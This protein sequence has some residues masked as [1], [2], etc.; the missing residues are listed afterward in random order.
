MPEN[1]RLRMLWNTNAMW[2]PSGYA[3]VIRDLAP[4]IR[5]EGY[6][7]GIINFYGQ[8][9]GMFGIEGIAQYP[10]I[11]DQWGADAMILHQK[12]FQ[13]D[14]VISLQ[15]IWVL[16]PEAVKQVKNWI[17]YLPID[18]DPIPP[19][20]FE[21][22]KL[23]YR[24]IAMSKF[25][26]K[27]LADRGVHSTYIPHMVNTEVFRP[28]DKVQ[29]RKEL[30]IPQD[31]YMFGMVSANKDNPPRKSFQEV[32]DAFKMFHDKYPK[33]GIYFH[34]MLQ[35]QGGFQIDEYARLL[36]IRDFVYSIDPYQQMYKV[37]KVGMA[38]IYNTFDCLLAPSTSEGF[39]IPIIEAQA[40]GIPVIVNDFTAMPEH[41]VEGKTGWITK[42]AS[43]RFTLLGS[44]IGIPDTMSIYQCME[45]SY[46]A[47]RKQ[48]AID[49]RKHMMDNYDLA[50]GY[51]EKW[52]PFFQMLEKELVI[53]NDTSKQ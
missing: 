5:D 8:E 33:S 52:K 18:H 38:R 37:D 51:K 16:N 30:G 17:T 15:D 36:G 7:I 2:S 40:C 23:A 14:C 13:A 46:K 6:P 49:C 32:M 41:V 28:L 42:V 45:K 25:G 39:G 21:R 44:Y 11:A 19:A 4:L 47:D 35:Q 1:R 26:Q 3:N 20:V 34:T 12:D 9:G 10:K 53:D 27:Q 43:K 50:T 31:Y 24:I 48:M 22:C 29:C